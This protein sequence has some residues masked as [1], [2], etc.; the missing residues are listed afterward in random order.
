MRDFIT[1][2]R[3]QGVVGLAIGFILGAAVNGVITSF[4]KDILQPIISFVIGTESIGNLHFGAIYYGKFLV[5]S[6]DFILLAFVVYFFFKKLK[7]DR[8]DLKE[9]EK[10]I[11]N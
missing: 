8:L 2:I 9:E 4:V 7:L 10:L 1:F 11:K 5:A 6:A 3:T